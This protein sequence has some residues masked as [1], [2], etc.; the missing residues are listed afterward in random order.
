MV[1]RSFII[2]ALSAL[3]LLFADV[4]AQKPERRKLKDAAGLSVS[5]GRRFPC[6]S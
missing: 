5:A 3:L 2:L 6:Y 4:N 1:S